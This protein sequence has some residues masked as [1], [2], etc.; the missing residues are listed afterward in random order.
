[1][2]KPEQALRHWNS[3][4]PIHLDPDNGLINRTWLVGEPAWAVLQWVN[5]IFDGSIHHDIE[6]VT[7]RLEEAGLTTPRLV[8]TAAGDLWWEDGSA[9]WR[10]MTYIPGSTLHRV[11]TVDQAA[12]AGKFVGRFHSAL[13]GWIYSFKARR[14]HA[15]DTTLHMSEL[16][17]A[18][19]EVGGHPLAAEANE[20]GAEILASWADWDGEMPRRHRLTHGDLK[21]SNL[22]FDAAGSQAVCLLD[23]DTL[24]SM[25]IACEMGDAWR[26]WC[27]PAG[28]DNPDRVEF[29]LEIFSTSAGAWLAEAPPLDDTERRALVPSIERICLELA[30]RYCADTVRNT[31]FRED[32]SRYPERGVHNLIRARSQLALAKSVREKRSDCEAIVLAA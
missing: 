2:I 16:H 24:G 5:P 31:Y 15:H 6:A 21:I 20:V 7:G 3:E 18:R 4:D 19:I 29:D 25:P 12:S 22:R 27:N 32:R 30:A 13:E 14:R 8:P 17:A 23:L 11:E 9:A 1:M 26:S 10:L 28:E